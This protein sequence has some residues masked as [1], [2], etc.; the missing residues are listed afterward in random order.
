MSIPLLA[1]TA[2]SG[3]Q[4]NPVLGTASVQRG[5]T[6][7]EV[8]IAI[9]LTALVGIGV[10]SLVNQLVTTQARFAE[11]L[12]LAADINF[13]QLLERRLT[14]LVVRPVREQGLVQ[15][16]APLDYRPSLQRLEWVSLS[17]T[18]LPLGDHY[19]RLR[20]QRLEWHSD[21]GRLT[22]LS[23]GLLDAAGKTPWQPVATLEDVSA[24][25]V[26]FYY[27]GRWHDATPVDGNSRGVR[28]S[29]QRHGEAI[30]LM[31]QLPELRPWP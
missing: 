20:R 7:L 5:F 23:S 11:P 10:A 12:P 8:L 24:L 28:L 29:W 21:D 13:S 31:A 25:E 19:T 27:S 30:I 16:N 1:D 14:A 2:T 18:P 17:G 22:L 3:P 15:F 4:S 26:A 9:A 6:L